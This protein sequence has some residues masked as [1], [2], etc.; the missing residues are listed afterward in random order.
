MEIITRTKTMKRKTMRKGSF[1]K[2]M[3][4]QL[5][6]ARWLE[7][8][9]KRAEEMLKKLAV[10][11]KLVPHHV[12]F[13]ATEMREG[14]WKINGDTIRFSTK[15]LLDGQHRLHAVI[16]SDTTI[17][18]LVVEEL[19]DAAFDTIDAGARIRTA[20]DMVS[21]QG[22][23]S[24]PHMVAAVA[25][26]IWF[27]EHGMGLDTSL[28]ISNHEIMQIVN[29]NSV[30]SL[31]AEY[32]AAKHVMRNSSIV[33]GLVLISRVAGEEM[34][35]FFAEKLM[36]GTEL[37]SDSPIRFFRDKWMTSSHRS[38]RGERAAWIAILIKTYNAWLTDKKA[39]QIERWH[40]TDKF[41]EVMKAPDQ[42]EK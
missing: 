42:P 33:A 6:K 36:L 1:P 18:A 5:P 10:N 20:G 14:R 12:S 37:K 15:R 16:Q 13:L 40:Y 22:K 3:Q 4:P 21:A 29:H 27:Y 38:S 34:T 25:R 2:I 8:D 23:Y 41:P 26:F 24:Q 30:I 11:R 35:M 19:E 32:A 31:L 28:R 39:S 7:I 9:P 17:W